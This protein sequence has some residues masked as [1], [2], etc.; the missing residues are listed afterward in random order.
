MV[1]SNQDGLRDDL[2]LMIYAGTA[3]VKVPTDEIT[4]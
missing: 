3:G 1:E 4:D 2:S